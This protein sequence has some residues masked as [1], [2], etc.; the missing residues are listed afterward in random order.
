M[1]ARPCPA[2]NHIAPRYLDGASQGAYVNYYRCD[3]CGLVFN[4]S[5]SRPNAPHKVVAPGGGDSG[6][7]SATS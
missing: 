1:P 5:K 2:C 7:S 6:G 4:V 3:A